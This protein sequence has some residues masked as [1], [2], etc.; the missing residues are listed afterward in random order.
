MISGHNMSVTKADHN[1]TD[2]E[3]HWPLIHRIFGFEDSCLGTCT[4][5]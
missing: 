5:I 3:R 1:N 4:W 2:H